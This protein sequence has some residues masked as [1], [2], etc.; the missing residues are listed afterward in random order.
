MRF[1]ILLLPLLLVL[2][3][4]DT[5]KVES[6]TRTVDSASTPTTGAP[7]SPAV[8]SE[9]AVRPERMTDTMNLDGGAKG[10]RMKLIGEGLP[11]TTYYP[12]DD[13]IMEQNAS[14]EGVGLRFV[15]NFGGKRNDSI[16][17]HFFFPSVRA[18]LTEMNDYVT[19]EGGAVAAAEWE[20]T[21]PATMNCSWA[22]VS[23]LYRD[24]RQPGTGGSI[25]IGQHAGSAFYLITHYPGAE[26]GGLEIR[27]ARILQ[28]IRWKDSGTGLG[29]E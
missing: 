16:S 8:P 2:G 3:C 4:T 1:P 29:K 24:T 10:S 21:G 19:G 5:P 13:L 12:E 25:C 15:G 18:G 14:D 27:L 20:I 23:Y 11:F 17:A 7:A 22:S 6:A 9:P 26:A 28:H